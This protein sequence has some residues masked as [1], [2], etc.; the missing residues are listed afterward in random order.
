MLINTVFIIRF[1]ERRVDELLDA[2]MLEHVPVPSDLDAVQFESEWSFLRSFGSKKKATAP[3]PS[4]NPPKSPTLGPSRSNA[5]IGQTIQQSL[6]PRTQT[7]TTP[8]QSLFPDGPQ[9]PSP[10]DIVSFISALHILMTESGINPALITQVW[11]Q[12][13]YWISS[14]LLV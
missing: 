11:S 3:P 5:S 9:S 14:E 10:A 1:A 8:L 6:R 4:P 7:G 13:M 12:V 2:A